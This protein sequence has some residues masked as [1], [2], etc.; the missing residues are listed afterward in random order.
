VPKVVETVWHTLPNPA[1][2][3]AKSTWSVYARLTNRTRLLPDYLI[4]GTQRGGTTSLYR[5]LVQH[6]SLSHALNK[7][8]RFFD[9]NYHRGW[10]WYRSRFPSRRYG[11]LLKRTKGVP[12]VVGEASP[13]YMYHPHAP[14]R[15]A[16]SLPDVKLIV[17]LRNPVDRAFSDYWHQFKRGHE[18]LSFEE[19]L[20]R[21]PERLGGEAEK[22]LRDERYVSYERQHHSYVTRGVYVDQLKEWMALFPRGHFLIERSEDFFENPSVVFKRVLDFLNVPEWDLPEYATYNAYTSGAMQPMT[23]QRLVEYFR[24]HNER[25]NAFLGRDFGWGA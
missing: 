3:A 21:E 14:I 17:L 1:K 12:L 2:R 15:V 10:G 25:L 7:E 20:D 5:Y 9:L 23:R 22:V 4:I 24:P 8:L 11:A 16:R 18:T 13:D 19:A 6:P